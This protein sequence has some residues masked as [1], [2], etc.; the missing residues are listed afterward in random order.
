MR[1]AAGWLSA[2]IGVGAAAV[3]GITAAVLNGPKREFPLYAFSPFEVQVPSEDV[4]FAAADGVTL[5]GWWF[6]QPDAETVVIC[7]HG[8]R[9]N[10]ADM[11]GIGSGLWR[12]GHSV[13]LFDFRGN[14]DSGDGPQSLAHHEQRDL[15]AAIDLVQR[16]RSAARIAVVAFSMGAAAAI[17]VAADDPRVEVLVADSSFATMS[18]VVRAA[19]GKHRLPQAIVPLA[20]VASRLW[21][22]YAFDDV[23]PLDRIAEIAPR[24]LLLLHGTEDKVI[25]YKHALRLAAAAGPDVELVTFEG[26][27]HCGGYFQDR[28][29]YIRLV[30]DFLA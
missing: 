23:R 8:H 27:E 22:G 15:R 2:G 9:G 28:T 29:A 14:G 12:E 20:S 3:A 18:D 10:K 7:C 21:H 17:L 11:L 19:Y 16:R 26:A 13:L 25:P 1:R 4:S 24:P 5:A 30:T 6:D